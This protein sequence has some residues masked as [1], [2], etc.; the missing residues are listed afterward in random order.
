M[1]SA[2]QTKATEGSVS[3]TLVV[4]GRPDSVP[5]VTNDTLERLKEQVTATIISHVSHN[6]P[7]FKNMYQALNAKGQPFVADLASL[8][9]GRTILGVI[10]YSWSTDQQGYVNIEQGMFEEKTGF[11]KPKRLDSIFDESSAASAA[12]GTRADSEKSDSEV[13][14][15]STLS[16]E[17]SFTV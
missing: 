11:E 2:T 1:S 15:R 14:L 7:I 12:S 5:V 16:I 9:E 17:I 13:G 4:P 6:T 10:T 3:L 8:A